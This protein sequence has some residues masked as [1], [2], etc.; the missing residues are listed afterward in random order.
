VHANGFGHPFVDSVAAA[1]LSKGTRTVITVHGLP[2]LD[3]RSLPVRTV[4]QTYLRSRLILLHHASAIAAPTPA[5]AEEVH[6]M[7]R[8]DVAVIPWGACPRRSQEGPRMTSFPTLVAV[9]R[10]V[11]LK[12][13]EILIDSLRIF[14]H[15]FPRASLEIIGPR[16]HSRYWGS[17]VR[18]VKDCGLEPV[19]RFTGPATHDY[20]LDAL[21]AADI[22]VSTSLQESF[23]LATLEA[24]GLGTPVVAT[25]VGIASDAVKHGSGLLV[26]PSATAQEVATA[27]WRVA[28]DHRTIRATAERSAQRVLQRYS[29]QKTASHY[30]KLMGF[31]QAIA[32]N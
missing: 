3:R 17:L 25:D 31:D 23:G 30:A 8:R 9:G 21:R 19:V 1:A 27:L 5:I 32:S 6:A 7:C 14:I 26:P 20:C 15:S 28:R 22:Y 18:R 10:V 13:F 12:N 16:S 29:W 11:P 4:A 24:A 2:R